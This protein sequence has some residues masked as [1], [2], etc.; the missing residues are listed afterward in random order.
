LVDLALTLQK[1]GYLVQEDW[2]VLIWELVP[3]HVDE[4][5]ASSFELTEVIDFAVL[6]LGQHQVLQVVP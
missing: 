5:N 4:L 2:D 3:E 6:K 1:V